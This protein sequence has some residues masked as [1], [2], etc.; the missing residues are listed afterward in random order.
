MNKKWIIRC[1]ALCACAVLMGGQASVAQEWKLGD[2][3]YV[4]AMQMAPVTGSISLRVEGLAIGADSDEP[5]TEYSL[6]GAEFGVYVFSGTGELTPWANPLYPSEQMRI[7]TGEAETYFSLPQGAEYY[8]KQESAPNGYIFDDEMLIPV[9]D[10]EIVVQNAMAGQ[11]V[12]SAVD[13]LGTPISGVEILVDGEDG[14][15]H[16]LVTNESGEAMLQAQGNQGFTIREGALPEGVFAALSVTG[17]QDGQQSAYAQV[18]P[19]R[20]TRVVF[21]HPAS[22]SVQLDMKL[23]VIDE[24][25][26]Q[27]SMPLRDVRLD[28]LGDSGISLLTDEQGRA[29]ASLLEGVYDVRLS[30]EGNLDVILP[31]SEGQ[32]IVSSGSTTVI[33]LSASESTGRIVIAAH[34]EKALEGGSVLLVSEETG[35]KYGPY[36]MD[37]DGLVV[38]A[39]LETGAYRISAFELAGGVQFGSI[40]CDG[41]EAKNPDELL[42]EVAS[43]KLTQADVQLLTQEKQMFGLVAESV[44][45][46]G[47]LVQ[48]AI[49]DPVS[50]V[51]RDE[52]GQEVAVVDS[53]LGIV[54]IEALSGRYTLQMDESDAQKLGIQS[55]SAVFDMPSD[56]ETIRFAAESTRLVLSSVDENGKPAPG[57]A[58]QLTDSIGARFEV[59]CDEDGMAVTP[60]L[61]P[62]EVVIETL[63]APAGYASAPAAEAMAMAGQAAS[64]QICHESLG[65][66]SVSVSVKSLDEYGQAVYT[67]VQGAQVHLFHVSANGQETDTGIVLVTD[68]MGLAQ[69]SL[70]AGEYA[71]AVEEQTLAQSWSG[72]QPVYLSV[73]NT[74]LSEAEIICRDAL[75]GVEVH[76]TG[77]E[78]SDEE[79]AQVRFEIVDADG[80]VSELQAKDGVFYAGGLFAGEYV[81]RQTQI[82][83]GYTIAAQ[84]RL[85]LEGGEVT[86]VDVPLEEYALL[87]VSKTGLTFDHQLN[88]YVV[89]LSGEYGVYTLENGEMQPYPDAVQQKT[90]WANVTPQEIALG[91]VGSVKLPA[92]IDG[93]IYYLRELTQAPGFAPDD[94]YYEICLYAGREATLSCAVSSDR[95]FFMLDAADT[96]S[97]EHIPGGTF[98]LLDKQSGEAVLT[99]EMGEEAYQN[100]MAVPVGEYI[101][102]QT[103]AAP[104]YALSEPYE[105]DV[106]VEP[107]LS[108][109]GKTNYV[110]MTAPSVPTETEMELFADIYAA[111][112]QGLSLLC[113]DTAQVTQALLAPVLTIRVDAVGS[114]RSDIASVVI[115]GTGDDAGTQYQARIEYCLD[116]GGWQHSDAR[117]TGVLSGPTAVSLDD[118]RDDIRA[119]RITY[120]DAATQEECSGQGFVPGQVTLNIEASAQGN[121]NMQAE[122]VFSGQFAYLTELGGRMQ[123]M[124]RTANAQLPFTVRADGLFETVSAGRDGK[125]SGIAFFDEDADGVMDGS[126][127]SRY[128]GLTVT[129]QTLSGEVLDTVR[130]DSDGRYTF[131]ALSGGEYRVQ[132]DAG[133]SVVF[134]DGEVFSEHVISGVE[135]TRYGTSEKIV[136][137]GEHTDYLVNVGCIFASEVTGSVLESI[138]D[139]QKA[140]FTGLTVEMRAVHADEDEEPLVVLSGG[141]GEFSF[142]RLLPGE[143][144]ITMKIPQGYLC[145]EAENSVISRLIHLGSGESLSFDALLL[146]K[147]ASVRGI[148][149]VDDDGDGVIEDGA[150]ILEG[151][152]V[153]L[154]A[155]NGAHTEVIAQTQTDAYGEYAFEHLYPGEYSVL[156]E[157]EGDWAFTRYGENSQVYGAVSQSGSTRTFVLEPGDTKLDVDAGV[158]IPA[159]LTVGVFE[160]AQYDGLKGVYEKMLSGVGVSLIR[161]E[162]GQD[163]EAVTYATAENGMVVF[164]GVSPGEYVIAY[165]LPGLWRTTKQVQSESYPV[166]C[167]P[168]SMLSTGRSEPFILDMNRRE[169]QLF[170]GAMLSGSIAGIV[171]YDDDADAKR[172][173]NEAACTEVMVELLGSSQQVIAS[174]V[175]DAEGGYAFDGL[176][177]ARYTVR[178]TAQE[179]CGFSGTERTAVRGGV[180]ESESNVSSTRA[181]TVTGGQCASAADAGVVRLSSVSGKLWEDQNADRLY[182]GQETP[183]AGV[184]V[185]LM[186]GA[187]RNILHTTTTDELGGFVFD[188]LKPATYQI[189]MD[190]PEEYVFSGA[191]AGSPLGLEDERDG[192]GYSAAF[193]LLGGVEVQNVSFGLLTQGTIGGFVWEDSDFDGYMGGEEPG[194]RGMDVTLLDENGNE[195]ASRQTLRSGEFVF[196]QLMPGNYALRVALPE[197]YAFTTDSAESYAPHDAVLHAVIE[198]GTL[199]MGGEISDVRIGMLKEASIGG[200]VWLDQDDDG[201]RQNGDQGISGV[202]ARIEMTSG[203]DAGKAYETLT[204][205][206]GV[207]RFDGMMPGEAV[208]TFELADGYAFARRVSGTR[209]VSSVEKADAL[210]ASTEPFVIGCGE[211][212]ADMDVGVVGVGTISGYVWEDETYDGR[213]GKGESGVLG[214]TMELVDVLSGEVVASV[215]T[216]ETGAYL[217]DFVR[218][219]EYRLNVSLPDRR[220]FTREGDSIIAAIDADSAQSVTMSLAMGESLE[221]LN[222]GT[223]VP[224]SMSGRV[225]IDENE[226]GVF[227]EDEAGLHGAVV[228]A[229]QGGTVFATTHADENGVFSFDMLRPGTYRLRYVLGDETLFAQN[230]H[231]NMTNADAI[232][233]ETGEYALSMG[234]RIGV[235]AVGV[236]HAAKIAGTAWMDE[237]VNASMDSAEPALSGVT[238][239]LIR[240]DGTVLEQQTTGSDGTYSFERLRSGDYRVRFAIPQGVLFTDYTGKPADSCVPVTAGSEGETEVFRLVMGEQ[241]LDMNVGGILPGMIGDTVWFDKDGNGLQDYKEPL[242]SGVSLTLLSVSAD[243]QM[244]EVSTMHS[245]KYGYYAF[246]SL[247]PGTYVLRMNPQEGDSLTFCFGAPL[248]EIDSDINPDTGMSAQIALQSGQSLRNID[249]GLTEH[250]E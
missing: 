101:L 194:L 219:G 67:P 213:F 26:E 51:L 176:A 241:R 10:G 50:L 208:M 215:A 6:P 136:I 247:R 16:V 30:Y 146:E 193:M 206:N 154:L 19:A 244:T 210:T 212:R 172:D 105:T 114:E 138:E 245:D 57:G 207:Y 184:S 131:G 199:E 216:D 225:V 147:E 68:D 217:F 240:S 165:E 92:A 5:V 232:D 48:N 33:E 82:P 22:G 223:I 8:L 52:Q 153:S 79:K 32:M 62:G 95:G 209:R 27:I 230:A 43:G 187:G 24:H 113:V 74:Q 188:H 250:A 7:R 166:S 18:S 129:L 238:A 237:N 23:S 152:R 63:D 115:A 164:E 117:M 150:N 148:V 214:A 132:F 4:P 93:T 178:F 80:S 47:A 58:Y 44:D 160:D 108:E 167:V 143:Y 61:A 142:N 21:E 25:A 40:V 76:L 116:G 90:L 229:M 78:L 162:N 151:V 127:R 39:P 12:I 77:G 64:I 243:G 220:I 41:M 56:E 239:Q 83:H 195:I 175:P 13:S 86:V 242:I 179:G 203:A 189:R 134:S 221:N 104:G 218:R 227:S 137:D 202:R 211:N 37:A 231:L 3:I 17:G 192:R 169:E 87:S 191:L 49:A 236:V 233:A 9:T 196:D 35:R 235:D 20:R 65:V 158:T 234:E 144:E 155:A 205:E 201:R 100:P 246:E 73:R 88:T 45:E 123:R 96:V 54:T 29:S 69:V 170:I 181:I 163:A 85:A 190:A 183:M 110:R 125:I 140:G 118:V 180:L 177:P 38:S 121:V 60:L 171:Y 84:R 159:R 161:I 99:F 102:R 122:A 36:A 94:S 111:Q 228:T 157:L 15:S 226:D 70:E 197:G 91:K 34:A 224:A 98:E 130:T 185:H 97:G 106:T 135:D 75:G 222:V 103:K 145:R 66:A 204:D 200:M 126:E 42:L 128:A 81:L 182:D 133:E 89:P 139:G 55:V 141:M 72:A 156:F 107:Y 71:A 174:A 2:Y 120:I 149:R 124:E 14:N 168:Q 46:H 11:L 186:D 119:V 198:L 1:A 112:E 248:G 173:E 59:I 249:V 28:I 53:L 109:G 31:L